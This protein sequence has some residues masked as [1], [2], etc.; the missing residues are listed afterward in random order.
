MRSTSPWDAAIGDW[1][2]ELERV[3]LTRR[4]G[5]QNN[6]HNLRQV[7]LGC[8]IVFRASKDPI[9]GLIALETSI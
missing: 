4:L 8:R 2:L 6:L 5:F 3:R 7:E 9:R 1:E